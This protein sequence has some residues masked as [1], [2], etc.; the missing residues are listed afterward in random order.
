MVVP[1][2]GT[3][4]GGLARHGIDKSRF[5][6]CGVRF[7]ARGMS[8]DYQLSMGSASAKKMNQ[9]NSLV[10]AA[11]DEAE[12]L[13]KKLSQIVEN[14]EKVIENKVAD[15]SS[16]HIDNYDELIKLKELLDDGIITQEEFD[17]KK[18]EIL[19]L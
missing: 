14:N 18:K 1:V 17:T 9:K 2:V 6:N 8:L 15:A 12:S 11:I 3:I 5:E 4:I 16:K 13:N 7:V 10:K 19:G